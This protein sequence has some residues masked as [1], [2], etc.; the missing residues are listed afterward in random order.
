MFI[1]NYKFLNIQNIF[2][3]LVY[4]G[5][6]KEYYLNVEYIIGVIYFNCFNKINVF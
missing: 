4:M 5:Y 6:N 1:C 3:F 2:M